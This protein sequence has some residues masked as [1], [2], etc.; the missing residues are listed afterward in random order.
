MDKNSSIKSNLF[1]ENPSI[2]NNKTKKN[3]SSTTINSNSLIFNQS[4]PLKTD[5]NMFKEEFR[6]KSLQDSKN[7][8]FLKVEN[9]KPTNNVIFSS[10]MMKQMKGGLPGQKVYQWDRLEEYKMFTKKINNEISEI[11]IDEN[12][13]ILSRDSHSM[14]NNN[15]LNKSQQYLK[16]KENIS[17]RESNENLLPEIFIQRPEENEK[18]NE[19]ELQEFNRNLKESKNQFRKNSMTQFLIQQNVEDVEEKPTGNQFMANYPI[20]KSKGE[21]QRY[22]VF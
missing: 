20:K 19:D 9:K 3:E 18:F 14:I 22:H 8:S 6:T 13:S 12:E 4:M 21:D 15:L 1:L 16:K 10:H 5:E 7:D 17:T 2:L 11:Q